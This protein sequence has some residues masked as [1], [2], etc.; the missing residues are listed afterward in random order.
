[1]TFGSAKQGDGGGAYT[2]P[3]V[4]GM[5][6]QGEPVAQP[7]PVPVPMPS[8]PVYDETPLNAGPASS[9]DFNGYKGEIQVKTV[10]LRCEYG[11]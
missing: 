8:A 6:I 3:V 11:K 7:V 4:Q 2:A 1:M 5:V 9:T 10:L